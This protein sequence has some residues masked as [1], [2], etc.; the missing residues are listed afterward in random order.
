MAAELVPFIEDILAENHCTHINC[1]NRSISSYSQCR[2]ES[3]RSV[4]KAKRA[5]E[6]SPYRLICN[7]C[8]RCSAVA[9]AARRLPHVPTRTI[10]TL[11]ATASRHAHARQVRG[12]VQGRGGKEARGI[13]VL[14]S[15]VHSNAKTVI[16]VTCTLQGSLLMQVL[17]R[18]SLSFASWSPGH[19]E[20]QAGRVQT[21]CGQ[22]FSTSE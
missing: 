4:S 10:H 5:P 14:E 20:V 13:I 22:P 19:H 16:P 18:R 12:P 6:A 11:G 2:E 7:A 21:G 1:C 17:V 15:G 3:C 9:G 8:L